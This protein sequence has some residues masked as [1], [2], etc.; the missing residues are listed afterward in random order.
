MPDNIRYCPV[1]VVSP[2]LRGVPSGFEEAWQAA[3]ILDTQFRTEANRSCGF[4][5]HAGVRDLKKKLVQ[6]DETQTVSELANLVAGAKYSAYNFS[7]LS[8]WTGG[9]DGRAQDAEYHNPA[10]Q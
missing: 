7:N 3:S 8:K 1:E 6:F 5:V 4:H 10:T 2:I 9:N